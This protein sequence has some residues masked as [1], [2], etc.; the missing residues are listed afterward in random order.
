VEDRDGFAAVEGALA[1]IRTIAVHASSDEQLLAFAALAEICEPLLGWLPQL[2]EVQAAALAGALAIGPRSGDRMAVAA[3]FRSLL[4][5]AA[6]REPLVVR[7]DDAH[8]LDHGSAAALAFAARRLDS[9]ALGILITQDPLDSNRLELRDATRLPAPLGV[10]APRRRTARADLGA[11]LDRAQARGS[12]ADL[13]ATLEAAAH[14]AED[15]GGAEMHLEAG[16]AWLEAGHLDRAVAAARAA[17][18]G[19]GDDVLA[20]KAQLLL[21]RIEAVRGDGRRSAIHLKA[22]ADLAAGDAPV[23]AASAE[24]LLVP[25]ALNGGRAADAERALQSSLRHLEAAGADPEADNLRQFA[26]AATTALALAAGRTNDVE[27]IVAL[28]TDPT[29]DLQSAADLS[30]LVT[31]VALPLIWQERMVEASTLLERVILSLR[32][33]GAIGALPLPLCA[34]AVEE[35]RAGRP[36]RSVLLA[37]EARDLAEQT[38]DQAAAMFAY[39]EIANA[40]SLFGDVERTRAAAAVLLGPGGPRRGILRLSALSALATVE[41]MAGNAHAVVE[42]LEP[43]VE[44]EGALSPMVALFHGTLAVAYITLGRSDDAAPLVALLEEAAPLADGRLRGNLARVRAM[45]ASEADRDIRF[46]DAIERGGSNES[47]RSMTTLLFAR[48]LLADGCAERGIDLLQDLAARNEENQLLA[49]RAARLSLARLGLSTMGGDPTWIDLGPTE[50]GVALATADRTTVL[51]LAD[52][53][54]LSPPE[55]E[56]VRDDVLVAVGARSGPAVMDGLLRSR[57]QIRRAVPPFEIRLLGGLAVF[58]DGVRRDV[59]A[60][61][62]ATAVALLALHRAVHLEELTDVLW[63]DAAPEIGRRR[64]RNVL[65]RI[66]RVAGPL[67]VR[68][69]ERIEIHGGAV[70]DHHVLESRARHALG[71]PEGPERLAALES[72]VADD[73]GALLPE[74]QYEDWCDAARL[75][76]EC[77]RLDLLR[78]LAAARE[79][80]GDAGGA[81]AARNAADAFV[82]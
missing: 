68:E 19:G 56:R 49:A 17:V 23:V 12:A 81:R 4:H 8:L 53:L 66:R 14:S 25:P 38:G 37:Y 77:R 57:G 58:V 47:V 13:A 63:P 36:S 65:G 59:P 30:L 74:A 76:T 32:N 73:A 48:R 28:A 31:M 51:D 22:A 34:L 44:G 18:A 69:G 15:I 80:A 9:V 72:L 46:A 27:P 2:P 62:A 71:L 55:V 24:L 41:L 40:H 20:A 33:R 6:E 5:V 35:R 10:N 16:R 78:C 79:A 29:V 21:G 70:V 3:G 67:L 54:H 45:M 50:L 61:A 43:E 1:S 75:R 52:R 39:A 64:L 82:G 7:V 26:A 60:G 42:L 11:A